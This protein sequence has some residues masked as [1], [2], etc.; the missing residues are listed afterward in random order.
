MTFIAELTT[1]LTTFDK[2]LIYNDNLALFILN[3][4]P[5]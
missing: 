3:E 2:I 5:E 4:S 1:P